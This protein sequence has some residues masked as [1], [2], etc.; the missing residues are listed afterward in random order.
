MEDIYI[1]EA[2]NQQHTGY[3]SDGWFV[4]AMSDDLSEL[5]V[6]AARMIADTD[7]EIEDCS[8]WKTKGFK[9]N[10]EFYL[11]VSPGKAFA[12][13]ELLENWEEVDLPENYWRSIFDLAEKIRRKRL[14]KAIDK[15]LEQYGEVVRALGA[16]RR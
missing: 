15:L 11:R 5:K 9:K 12:Y 13:S 4:V 3:P 7:I 8:V 2:Y 14:D 16:N 10:G 6:K 1:F